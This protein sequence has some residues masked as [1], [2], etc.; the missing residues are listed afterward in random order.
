MILSTDGVWTISKQHLRILE[1]VEEHNTHNRQSD[2]DTI[3]NKSKVQNVN[4]YLQDLIKLKF[5]KYDK[6]NYKLTISGMDCIA[7]NTLRQKGLSKLSCRIGIGKESDIWE[8]IYNNQKVVLKIH[9]LGRTSFKSIKNKRDYQKGKIDWYKINKISCQREVQYY[10]IFQELDIPKFFDFDRHIIVLEL[11]DYQPLY[12][13]KLE[14]PEIIYKKMIGFIA[15]LWNLGYVHGDFNEFNVMAKDDCIKV[16]DFPQSLK[17][18]HKDAVRYL[19][20]DIRCVELY[21]EKKYGLLS[22]TNNIKDILE[23]SLIS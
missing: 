6:P 7:L 5:L 3:K 20:R 11:L 23:N 16:L 1:I 14:H 13:T 12:M 21:F 4:M 10:E 22:V 18:T 19:E 17:T 15:E 2:M 9:R 8:G